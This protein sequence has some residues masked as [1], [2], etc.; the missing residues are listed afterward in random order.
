MALVDLLARDDVP[1]HVKQAIREEL[2]AARESEERYRLLAANATDMIIRLAPDGTII[3]VSPSSRHL[4]GYDPAELIGRCGRDFVYPNDLGTLLRAQEALLDRPEAQTI[5]WRL[6]HKNGAPVWIE[7]TTQAVRGPE[8]TITE[9]VAVGRD[10]SDRKRAEDE[11]AKRLDLESRVSHMLG[12]LIQLPPGELDNGIRE[13]LEMLS[14]S[15]GAQRAGVFV[16]DRAAGTAARTHG[17]SAHPEDAWDRGTLAID[18]ELFA[19]SIRLMERG[20]I[21]RV[22]RPTDLPRSAVGEQA[23]W[24]A[25]GF[26][27]GLFF[28]LGSGETLYG[29]LGFYGPTGRE[30]AWPDHFISL[31]TVVADAL[32]ALLRRREAE[33]ALIEREARLQSVFRSAPVGI[34]LTRDRVI[35][36]ANDRLCEMTGYAREELLGQSA[37][38]L[39][40]SDEAYEVV[41]REKYRQIRE[42]GTGTVETCWRRKDGT[43]IDVL[44]SST[45]LHGSEGSGEI[46]FTAL[47]ITARK[48]AEAELRR[49]Q[50]LL[51]AAI[52]QS[53]SGIVIAD[54]PDVRVRMVNAAAANLR[55]REPEPVSGDPGERATWQ[56]H[57]RRPDGTAIAFGD[58][59]LARA[60]QRGE[61]VRNQLLIVQ[62]SDG[63]ERWIS[64]NA[65]PVRDADG[66]VRAGIVVLNDITDLRRAEEERR[67]LEAQVQHTQKLESLGVLAGGIAHDFN[68]M[69]VG[70]LGNAAMALAQL[71]PE[72][73]ARNCLEQ[74]ETAALRAADLA[75]QM[76]AYSGRGRF[77][78]ETLDLARL[79]EEM[80]HLLESSISK[81]A[82]LRRELEPGVAIVEGDATQ[83]RQIVM[84]LITNASEALDDDPGVITIAASVIEA[85]REY[86]LT[87]Y[88]DDDLQPGRYVALEVSDTGHGMDED[89]KSRMFDPFFSTKRTGRG[90]GMAAVLGIV[91]GHGGAIKVYSERGRGTCVKVL[92]PCVEPS[93]P[94]AMNGT[95]DTSAP[96][97]E[98]LS[99]TILVADDEEAVRQV[100]RLALEMAGFTVI[101]AAD[102]EE[103]VECFAAHA[104]EVRAILLDLSM[105]KMSGD[106]AFAAIKR[107]R[108]DVPVILSSGFN[109]QD[110]TNRLAGR[111]LAGFIQK[112]YRPTELIEKLRQL[113]RGA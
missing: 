66:T 12:S 78:V 87:T 53:S 73:P 26:R 31:V 27:A 101:T 41:G 58:L 5:E 19:H 56:W 24:D 64:A 1:E 8:G 74:I 103:A 34:G 49:T 76:L 107:I 20:E 6:I 36:E 86:L 68:N 45:P 48:S 4:S 44:L 94:S 80:S 100:T 109:E 85:D 88:I 65:A 51:Q 42:Q 17:W 111:G 59:P 105:P 23:L 71:G 79:V 84:N 40:G 3:D 55:G 50:G 102:G 47:D 106:E 67:Q 7:T 110:T 29:A 82:V 99:G 37:R 39:Y 112:P 38:M 108:P 62:G 91:R 57:A 10:I 2:D 97:S 33:E 81:K 70:V 104:S 93:V 77:V 75:K 95:S 21:L 98:V 72:S 11:L 46:T 25:D 54:A 35:L 69:L 16:I 96:G 83:L 63:G 113:L 28:P 30:F 90:L 15:V 89:T 13:A 52:D 60:I 32:L 92:L 61:V 9:F 43:F 14:T 22:S 18:T